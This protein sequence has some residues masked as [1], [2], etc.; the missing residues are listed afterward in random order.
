M[1]STPI[2]A[3]IAAIIGGCAQTVTV[4]SGASVAESIGHITPSK[5]DTCETQKQIA[6]QSSRI[7]TI[8]TGKETVYKSAPC[9][10]KKVPASQP[11]PKTS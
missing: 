4:T 2:V 6:A 8:I 9:T 11:D 10:E 5:Q 7:D 1:K 3:C